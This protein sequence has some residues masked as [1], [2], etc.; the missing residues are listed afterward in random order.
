MTQRRAFPSLVLGSTS[1]TPTCPLSS[2]L[3]HLVLLIVETVTQVR[4]VFSAG[5]ELSYCNPTSHFMGVETE[6]WKRPSFAQGHCAGMAH[7]LMRK[8]RMNSGPESGGW[9]G[10]QV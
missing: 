8:A 1:P 10:R 3:I 2:V 6:A 5:G 9:R 7:P 4:G